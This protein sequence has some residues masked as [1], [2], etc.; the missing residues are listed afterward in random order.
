MATLKR[1]GLL[2]AGTMGAGIAQRA[3]IEGLEVVLVDTKPEFLEQSIVSIRKRLESSADREFAF[4]ETVE[5]VIGRITCTTDP[6]LLKPV[7]FVIESIDEEIEQKRASLKNISRICSRET[8][9]ATSANTYGIDELASAISNPERLVGMH[10]SYH[11]AKNRLI[12]IVRTS[13][14]SDWTIRRCQAVARAI[15][16]VTILS[17]DHPGFVV[18][19]L[20]AA[21][22]NEGVR[23]LT[24]GE[25][26]IP[27]VEAGVREALGLEVGPFELMNQRG[28]GI[29]KWASTGLR[30]LSGDCYVNQERLRAQASSGE[31]WSLDGE[32]DKKKIKIVV[33]R[34]HGLAALVGSEIVE[35]QISRRENVD[36]GARLGLGWQAGPFEMMNDLGVK[37]AASLAAKI[38]ELRN[39][40]IPAVLEERA[41]TDRPWKL[42]YVD[43][44]VRD[45]VATITIVRPD[46]TNALDDAV[47]K[48]IGDILNRIDDD[49]DVRTVVFTT[50]GKVLPFGPGPKGLIDEVEIG[51]T[52][53]ILAR[54]R[55]AQSL[56]NRIASMDKTT[57]LCT[58]GVT[59]GG[60][61]ELGLACDAI[62][63]GPRAI[64]ALPEIGWGIHSGL[65]G[66]QRLPRKV[67]KSI[68][69]YLLFTGDVLTAAAAQRFGVVDGLAEDEEE[70]D[71][72]IAELSSGGSLNVD[73]VVPTDDELKIISLFDTRRCRDTLA[74]D[75][76]ED[77]KMA[78][79]IGETL[80]SQAPIALTLVNKVIED[81]LGLDFEKACN[82]ELASLGL[83]LGT[84]D[85]LVGLKSIG[86]KPP[87]FKG[88]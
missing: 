73:D 7:S 24:D 51:E 59:V 32:P 75:L 36:R 35:E 11:P 53:A 28:I 15:G 56:L 49:A 80:A 86:A 9:F 34:F 13:R 33:D 38:A 69:K 77:N 67:G 14:T 30:D 64:F 81:G 88:E 60:G 17:K 61:L 42:K 87:K 66:T 16:G 4:S 18:K 85:A 12:E 20:L 8:I 19:R 83:I 40:G 79:R 57:V 55:K 48:Q 31:P 41:A 43:L 23:M 5:Q 39:T 22:L 70:L 2:G 76:P 84:K 1:I 21:F 27:T 50:Q 71:L 47:V 6:T 54:Y 78:Q 65:G 63:A 44:E 3:A 58:R 74:G 82:L 29:G 62:V 68:G 45:G 46:A 37:K 25:A 52:K 26:D 10:F 72:L